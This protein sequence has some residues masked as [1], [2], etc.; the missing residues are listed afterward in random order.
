[1]EEYSAWFFIDIFIIYV[2]KG[3]IFPIEILG[4]EL[5]FIIDN[6]LPISCPWHHLLMFPWEIYFFAGFVLFS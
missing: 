6:F 4:G 5:S 1:M 3:F 2:M